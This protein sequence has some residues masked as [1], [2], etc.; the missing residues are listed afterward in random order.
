M[1]EKKQFAANTFAG[2]APER[3]A[4]AAAATENFAEAAVNPQSPPIVDRPGGSIPQGPDLQPVRPGDLIT[5]LYVNTL[6]AAI[7]NLRTRVGAI[8]A[9]IEDSRTRDGRTVA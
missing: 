8:E 3:P 6:V 2:A 4:A 1:A 7:E 9:L 5:A